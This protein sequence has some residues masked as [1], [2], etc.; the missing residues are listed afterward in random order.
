[1]FLLLNLKESLLGPLNL[2]LV[3]HLYPLGLH[4]ADLELHVLQLS[5]ILE[6]LKRQVSW[7]QLYADFAC[8]VVQRAFVLSKYTFLGHYAVISVEVITDIGSGHFELLSSLESVAV[9]VCLLIADKWLLDID[10]FLPILRPAN[11]CNHFVKVDV[12]ESAHVVLLKLD[13][14]N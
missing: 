8:F 5:S 7:C 6:C 1:M 11:G 13:V 9:S 4:V 10:L 2:Q 12:F 3:V 14:L